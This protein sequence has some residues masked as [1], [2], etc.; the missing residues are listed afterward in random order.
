MHEI[1]KILID[2][3]RLMQYRNLEVGTNEKV[4]SNKRLMQEVLTFPI[5]LHWLVVRKPYS[6]IFV[7]VEIFV[8]KIEK[9]ISKVSKVL[10]KRRT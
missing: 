10:K 6:I 4:S 3:S 9:Y 8:T 7:L 1:I 5:R 2:V